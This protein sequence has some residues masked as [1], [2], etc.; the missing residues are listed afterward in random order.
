MNKRA[1]TKVSWLSTDE[2]HEECCNFCIYY[3]LIARCTFN[4]GV[5]KYTIFLTDDQAEAYFEI[6][7]EE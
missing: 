1:L 3:H 7:C 2:T 4:T 5:I 6:I